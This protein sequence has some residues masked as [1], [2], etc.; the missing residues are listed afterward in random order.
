MKK[1]WS[2]LLTSMMKLSRFLSPILSSFLA[3][4]S[5]FFSGFFEIFVFLGYCEHQ[6]SSYTSYLEIAP[7]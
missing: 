1:H 7:L 4:V 5:L 6:V 2:L 3:M